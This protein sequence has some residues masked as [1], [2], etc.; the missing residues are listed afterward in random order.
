MNT[1]DRLEL[2]FMGAAESIAK[3]FDD[4]DDDWSAMAAMGSDAHTVL[5]PIDHLLTALGG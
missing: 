2:Y 3:D 1:L 5:V 4:P